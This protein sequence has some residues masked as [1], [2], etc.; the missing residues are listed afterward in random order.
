M[1]FEGNSVE[2]RSP[3][4]S[5]SL[6]AVSRTSPPAPATNSLHNMDHWWH[7]CCGW[8]CATSQP[9]FRQLH[10]WSK[11]TQEQPGVLPS[12]HIKHPAKLLSWIKPIT[13]SYTH[14]WRSD[15]SDLET[16]T[17]IWYFLSCHPELCSPE[18]CLYSALR[19]ARADRGT[20]GQ[21]LSCSLFFTENTV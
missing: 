1:R 2:K 21:R 10:S 9:V 5:A 15:R 3:S 18:R 20:W 13:S 14:L 4:S 6:M 19:K 16:C 7:K 17:L 11:G 8:P 12:C